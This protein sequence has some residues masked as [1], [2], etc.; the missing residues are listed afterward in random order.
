MESPE[1]STVQSIPN[2]LCLCASVRVKNLLTIRRQKILDA[3]ATP[4]RLKETSASG[5]TVL[6]RL[7]H[8]PT[9]LLAAEQEIQVMQVFVESRND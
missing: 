2:P 5:I 4:A 8:V 7:E 9:L 1:P 3:E 6:R